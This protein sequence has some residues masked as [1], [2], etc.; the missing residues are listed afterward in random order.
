[1]GLQIVYVKNI[2]SGKCFELSFVFRKIAILH[3]FVNFSI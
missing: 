1:M 2:S 3:V